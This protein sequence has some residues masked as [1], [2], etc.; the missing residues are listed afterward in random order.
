M[1]LLFVNVTF[2]TLPSLQTVLSLRSKYE[3][4]PVAL[5]GGSHVG[6]LRAYGLPST[7]QD[8]LLF[9]DRSSSGCGVDR[10]K[11]VFKK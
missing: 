4:S 8:I 7:L 11:E 10:G 3:R 1:L 5:C 6:P 2:I 9:Q